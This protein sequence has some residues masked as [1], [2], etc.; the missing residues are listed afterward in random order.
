MTSPLN[1]Y[2]TDEDPYS[3]LYVENLLGVNRFI[4]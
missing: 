3:T 2:K 1:K 4:T